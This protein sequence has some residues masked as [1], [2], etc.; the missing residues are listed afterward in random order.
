MKNGPLAEPVFHQPLLFRTPGRPL[1]G[2]PPAPNPAYPSQSSVMYT[3]R[4]Q[5]GHIIMYESYRPT[6][7]SSGRGE[8][9]VV[10]PSPL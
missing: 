2:R 5:A 4:L 9:S 1:R 7:F 8:G 10:I 6:G 3:S